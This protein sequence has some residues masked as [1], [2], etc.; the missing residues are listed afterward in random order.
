[1]LVQIGPCAVSLSTDQGI[2]FVEIFDATDAT[3]TVE[4][5]FID[6]IND[7]V[8]VESEASSLKC[9]YEIHA[10]KWSSVFLETFI[11]SEYSTDDSGPGPGEVVRSYLYDIMGLTN[12]DPISQAISLKQVPEAYLRFTPRIVNMAAYVDLPRA[13]ING[14]IPLQFNSN[15]SPMDVSG[16]AL[17]DATNGLVKIK[18]NDCVIV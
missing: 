7:G 6:R 16:I 14:S 10:L 3:V 18:L 2:S 9:T 15:Q 4:Y 11:M 17:K 5:E 1:M 13:R 8:L 12:I